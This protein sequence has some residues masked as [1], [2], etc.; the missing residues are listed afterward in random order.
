MVNDGNVQPAG[1]TPSYP[2]L[3]VGV[4]SENDFCVRRFKASYVKVVVAVNVPGWL[5]AGAVFVTTLPFASYA[6]PVVPGVYAIAVAGQA[7][8]EFSG[9]LAQTS[10]DSES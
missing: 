9:L 7:A 2:Y 8:E 1:A 4:A 5:G 10:R 3:I 6:Y